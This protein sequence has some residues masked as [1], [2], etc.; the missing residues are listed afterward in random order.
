MNPLFWD[1][2]STF[3]QISEQNFQ[4]FQIFTNPKPYI[5]PW[6]TLVIVFY[7]PISR[8]RKYFCQ[9]GIPRIP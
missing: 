3:Q 4:I 7:A 6:W 8:T 2:F 9:F 1:F 5:Q